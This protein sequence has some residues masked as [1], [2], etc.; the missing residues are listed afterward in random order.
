MRKPLFQHSGTQVLAIL[1]VTAAA[2]A[3]PAAA[4]TEQAAT[5]AGHALLMND[6]LWLRGF[7]ATPDGQHMVCGEIRGTPG[8]ADRLGLALAQ[9]LRAQGAEAILAA[10]NS[11]G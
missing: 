10:L 11:A 3:L 1:A 4:Q 8:D 5:L 2:W 6:E 7:V 9:Q